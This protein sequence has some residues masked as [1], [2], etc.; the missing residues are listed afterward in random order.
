MSLAEATV[1]DLAVAEAALGP[2]THD[3]LL[4]GR[5]GLNQPLSG[6]RAATD[7]VLLAAAV[8]AAGGE[9]VLELGIG[10]GAAVLC[11]AA[12]VP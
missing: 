7:P 8:P 10:A 4:G 11:L 3:R 1:G 12:R 9:T 5:V 2:L 6:Y